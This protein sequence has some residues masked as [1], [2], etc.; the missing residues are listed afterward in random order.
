MMKALL[1]VY[2]LAMSVTPILEFNVTSDVNSNI[3]YG[4]A[5]E[6]K[7]GATIKEKT[8]S[9]VVKTSSK[10]NKERITRKVA[11]RLLG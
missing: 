4:I 7:R 8:T 6:G 5:V 1:V 11:S 9:E 3:Q 2:I 10:N